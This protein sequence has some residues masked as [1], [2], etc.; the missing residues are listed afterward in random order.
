MEMLTITEKAKVQSI[1]KNP[2][3]NTHVRCL[4]CCEKTES[5]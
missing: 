5:C 2:Q 1:V 3:E 4:I